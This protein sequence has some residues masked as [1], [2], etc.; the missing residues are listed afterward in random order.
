MFL[1]G[2]GGNYLIYSYSF[3][4]VN[5][6]I[7]PLEESNCQKRPTLPNIGEIVFH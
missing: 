5:S 2:F 3:G 4:P 6:R 1:V 7:E